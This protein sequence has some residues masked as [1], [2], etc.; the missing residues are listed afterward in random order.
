[1]KLLF[2][3]LIAVL[4]I[5]SHCGCNL[6]PSADKNSITGL[7][8]LQGN[9][10]IDDDI[11][12]DAY[13]NLREDKTYT[14]Y[15]P[16]YFDYGHWS[17]AGNKIALVSDRK[18]VL[19]LKEWELIVE[20]RDKDVL[21]ISYPF[22]EKIMHI[23]SL[24]GYDEQEKI[25]YKVRKHIFLNRNNVQ[26]APDKDPFSLKYSKW[27]I[28]PD[29]KESCAELQKRLAGNMTH[30]CLLFDQY[31][32]SDAEDVSW[33]HSPH[34]F[35]LASNGISLQVNS[36]IQEAWTN[37]FYDPDNEADAYFMLSA[38]FNEDIDVPLHTKKYSELWYTLIHQ[39][40][41]ITRHKS[42]CDAKGLPIRAGN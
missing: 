19:Y 2:R 11:E 12:E 15:Q 21:K 29:H 22:A 33:Q 3:T 34:P 8:N 42:L 10:G 5:S 41:S 6:L 24:T 17:F 28:H 7:W 32:R 25:V 1:M 36:T 35:F 40:D 31:A 9:G 16:Y 39:M 27:R 30:L 13:L 38:L 26:F 14:F 37:I 20:D 4:F 23:P 18:K